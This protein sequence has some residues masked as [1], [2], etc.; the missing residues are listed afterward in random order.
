MRL[1]VSVVA[2][3]PHPLDP[4]TAEAFRLGL[5][6]A[7]NGLNLHTKGSRL[8]GDGT[9]VVLELRSP[10]EV[11]VLHLYADRDMRHYWTDMSN[12]LFAAGDVLFFPD[13]EFAEIA[14]AAFRERLAAAHQPSSPPPELRFA[15]Y[16]AGAQMAAAA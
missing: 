6:E 16:K 8:L 10:R 7:V 3:P 13:L 11:F 1:Y 15:T 12:S 5:E 14:E 2:Y 9:E 4:A